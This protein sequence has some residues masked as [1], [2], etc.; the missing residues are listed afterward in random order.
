MLIDAHVHLQEPALLD[1]MDEV[2]RV[3][4]GE[5]IGLMICNGTRPEDW[6]DVAAI[7]SRHP[8]VVPA[9]AVHPWYVAEA[10]EAWETEL[11][12]FLKR[13]ASAVGE[14]GIDRWIEP[15][16]E[17]LQEAVFRRHLSI[18][19]ELDRPIMVHCLR[20]WGWLLE[21]LQ[22]EKLPAAMLIHSYG[23]SA[24]MVAPLAKM[25]AYF[26]FSGAIFEPKRQKLRDAVKTIPL[27]RLLVET[28]APALIPPEDRR[29]YHVMSREG[30]VQNHPANLRRVYEG[31]A[32]LL[33]VPMPELVEQAK[34]NAQRLLGDLWDERR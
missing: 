30:E 3:C 26:S 17:A 11:R 2:M 1:R 33:G 14:C 18:A 32:E 9:Y 13:H 12:D 8:E 6:P 7:A 16:N 23:G 10:G 22:S 24:E 25:N 20:A 5:G 34:A 31:I 19:S 29:S 21:I 27:D 15:R 4:V 28:D